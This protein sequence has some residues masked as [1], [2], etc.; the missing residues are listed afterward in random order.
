MDEEAGQV[1]RYQSAMAGR[2]AADAPASYGEIWNAE[3]GRAGLD[4]LTGQY[5]YVRRPYDELVSAVEGATGQP[6]ADYARA[7]GLPFGGGIDAR[8][9]QLNA[10]ADTLPDE[11]QER[12]KEFRDVRG[13]AATAAQQTEREA[14]A[15]ANRTYGFAA[16][17]WAWIAGVARQGVDPVG[18][19]ANVITAP[20]GGPCRPGA[21]SSG[22]STDL[23]RASPTSCSPAPGRAASRC[24]FGA[25]AQRCALPVTSS[26]VRKFR[27]QGKSYRAAERASRQT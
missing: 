24:Y 17:A 18:L 4:T 10:L 23:V 26:P 6:V 3:F 12:I 13:R 7:H 2:P 25:P 9:A 16:N 5:Q 19:G 20:V 14:S 11:Q 1:T 27:R 8:V 21:R 22:S 15:V